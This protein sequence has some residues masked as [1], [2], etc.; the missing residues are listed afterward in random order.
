MKSLIILVLLNSALSNTLPFS[1]SV[2]A[3]FSSF[4][5]QVTQRFTRLEKTLGLGFKL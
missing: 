2:E 5:A 1:K 4:A 3:R